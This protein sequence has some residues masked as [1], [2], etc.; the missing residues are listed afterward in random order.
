M[1]QER[2]GV[3]N[4]DESVAR[5]GHFAQARTDHQQHIGSADGIGELGVEA[6]A[7][8]P[9]VAGM[10]V[11]HVVLEPEGG[12]DGHVETAGESFDFLLHVAAPAGTADDHQRP[13]GA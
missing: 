1:D 12:S 6:D 5:G 9:D 4:V 11:V 3:W 13:L 7:G 8:M 2:F 10:P